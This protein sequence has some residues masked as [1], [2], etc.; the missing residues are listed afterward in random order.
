[1][2]LVHTSA[3]HT[4]LLVD[5]NPLWAALLGYFFLGEIVVFRTKM[6]MAFSLLAIFIIF[7][8]SMSPDVEDGGESV[9]AFGDLIAAATGAALAVY[10]TIVRLAARDV[11]KADMTAASALGGY[12]AAFVALC[13]SRGQVLP[14][15]AG[16]DQDK[17]TWQF[18]A[19]VFADGL[20]VG[21]IFVCLSIAPRLCSAPEVGLVLLLESVLG[22][23]WVFVGY[24]DVP[25]AYTLA[26]GGLLLAVLA[27]HELAAANDL[28]A[29]DGKLA[30]EADESTEPD[31]GRRANGEDTKNV[32]VAF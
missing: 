12:F 6:A 29:S 15:I 4:I 1:M 11:P 19:V 21:G 24:G 28:Q 32:L 7:V 3:A 27:A 14:S 5:L 10:L 17:P 30:V 23:L 8:P 18:F 22:P 31:D 2:A 26:G 13:V 20:C 9:T 16:Y 25:N